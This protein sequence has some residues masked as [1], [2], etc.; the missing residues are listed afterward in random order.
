MEYWIEHKQLTHYE[1]SDHRPD[2]ALPQKHAH[3]IKDAVHQQ[4]MRGC[5]NDAMGLASLFSSMWLVASR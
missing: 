2:A 1:C 4:A 3:T 5:C